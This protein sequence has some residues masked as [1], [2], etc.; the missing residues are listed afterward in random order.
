MNEEL[1]RLIEDNGLKLH[2]DIEHFAYLLQ[3]KVREECAK[4]C[5]EVWG[6]FQTEAEAMLHADAIR[7]CAAKIRA[8]GE[9]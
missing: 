7:K 2:G 6:V 9:K 4:V 5:G 8:K 1:I 3:Q